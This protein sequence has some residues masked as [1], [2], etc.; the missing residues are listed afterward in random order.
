MRALLGVVVAVGVVC[1]SGLACAEY[2]DRSIR[3]RLPFAA[4]GTTDIARA[5]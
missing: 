3:V 4:A 1:A 2:P 5:S